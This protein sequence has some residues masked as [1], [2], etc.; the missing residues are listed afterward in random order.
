MR[1]RA[2]RREA[3]GQRLARASQ[4]RRCVL[5]RRGRLSLVAA[6]LL[7]VAATGCSL[8]IEGDRFSDP[9]SD[10][11]N[12]ASVADAAA[13]ANDAG[14][15][16][17]GEVGPGESDAAPPACRG[18]CDECADGCCTDRCAGGRCRL[19]CEAECECRLDC[20]AADDDC[21]ATCR[22]ADCTIDCRGDGKCKARCEMDSECMI[23]CT[24]A[25]DCGEV[26][27]KE[28]S[29]CL[30]DC[31]GAE[32]CEF[33]RCDGPMLSCPGGVVACNRDCPPPG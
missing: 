33:R 6:A 32:R 30:L 21:E 7:F 14:R 13:T 15:S 12:G 4:P 31:S 22:S 29:S 25:R 5:H 24:N 16:D 20:R 28:G 3:L 17:A 9:R 26:E 27:C 2:V 1:E 10:A 11:G 18:E 8:L 19:E 23:N